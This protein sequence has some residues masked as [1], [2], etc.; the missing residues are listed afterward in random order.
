MRVKYYERQTLD[1]IARNILDQYN[2]LFLYMQPQS[3]PLEGIVQDM[4][5]LYIE[6]KRLTEY[7]DELGRII[8]NDGYTP[9]FNTEK[10]E[11]EYIKVSSGT[12]LIE[13][14]LLENHKLHG[15]LRFTIAHEL[16]HWVLHRELFAS[17]SVTQIAYGIGNCPNTN[18]IEWQANYLAKSLL[19]PKSQIKYAFYMMG[20]EPN[21]KKIVCL[22]N[23]FEVSKQSMEIRLNEMGLIKSVFV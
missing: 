14:L 17:M 6:Y 3:T 4:F 13:A 20:D 22:A 9:Y 11:Y 16:S 18:S 7:G 12:I 15:R 2:P 10:D 8:F 1:N 23:M 5:D 21:A 19:M